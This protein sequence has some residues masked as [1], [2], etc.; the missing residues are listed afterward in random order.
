MSRNCGNAQASSLTRP[1][2]GQL[3]ESFVNMP[4]IDQFAE[5]LANGLTLPQIREEMGLNNN[6]AQSFMARI[7]KA[8]G[9][10]AI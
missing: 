1:E 10:Q 5:H 9:T 8:L 6:Q 3:R 4:K 2:I 7:R